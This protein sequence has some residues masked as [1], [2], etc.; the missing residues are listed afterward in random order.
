MTARGLARAV[1]DRAVAAAAGRHADVV[2]K[3]DGGGWILDQFC[4]Q[5]Q[6][7]LAGR[8][9][10]YVTPVA[11]AGLRRSVVHFI[12]SECFY[13]PNWAR[14][15]HPSNAAIGTWWHGSPST[16]D[17]SVREAASR[18]AAVS[19]RLACVHVTCESSRAI[20]RALGVHEEKIAWSDRFRR[21]A[22][23]GEQATSPR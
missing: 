7:H 20:V 9:S 4:G 14:R 22:W 13:D 18:V 10:V 1:L 17:P 12:G 2:L 3:T 21:T 8:L 5:I 11:V 6:K 15:Y 19:G 16:P 23:V